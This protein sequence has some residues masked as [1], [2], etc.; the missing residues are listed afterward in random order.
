[1]FS[2]FPEITP[3]AIAL[4]TCH[5]SIHI[6]IRQMYKLIV[7]SPHRKLK[8]EIFCAP[9]SWYLYRIPGNAIGF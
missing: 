4:V 3:I 2:P 5:S 9:E 8:P 1:M 7:N 6:C